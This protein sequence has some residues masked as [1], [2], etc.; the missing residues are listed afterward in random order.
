MEYDINNSRKGLTKLEA[1]CKIKVDLLRG[2]YKGNNISGYNSM[3][4]LN[5][6]LLIINFCEGYFLENAIYGKKTSVS[7]TFPIT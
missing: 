5:M 3:S 2:F 7:K 1:Y 6:M 4:K